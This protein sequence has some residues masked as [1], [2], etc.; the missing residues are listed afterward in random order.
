ML[1][2]LAALARIEGQAELAQKYWP[3]L[4]KWA[5]YLCVFGQ[6]CKT[7]DVNADGKDDIVIFNPYLPGQ[8]GAGNVLVALS[9]GGSGEFAGLNGHKFRAR[10]VVHMIEAV[11]ATIPIARGA[12]ITFQQ[13][14]A[15]QEQ[16]V[17]D[18]G[19]AVTTQVAQINRAR[20]IVARQFRL[21]P[22]TI[23]LR[24]CAKQSRA[25]RRQCSRA[26][27]LLNTA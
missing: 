2:I 25:N 8:G 3:L 9:Q 22:F 5:D 19:I 14:L 10:F 27:D 12:E 17:T 11:R 20:K 24:Q 1:M 6:V 15:R 23:D 13:T 18:F 16:V 4:T 21:M 26:L 7:G